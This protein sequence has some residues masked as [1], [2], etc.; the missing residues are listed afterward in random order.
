MLILLKKIIL[1]LTLTFIVYT[2][3]ASGQDIQNIPES[4]VSAL[5][6][7]VPMQWEAS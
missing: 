7:M 2:G 6:S 1:V 5:Y 3:T 4:K